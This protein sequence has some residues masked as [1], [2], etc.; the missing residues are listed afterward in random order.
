M[1]KLFYQKNVFMFIEINNYA[2]PL[3]TVKETPTLKYVMFVVVRI[4]SILCRSNPKTKL[5]LVHKHLL[6]R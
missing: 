1:A 3:E 4:E 2:S 6:S 5:S